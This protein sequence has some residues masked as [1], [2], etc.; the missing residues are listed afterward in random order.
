MKVSLS[1]LQDYVDISKLSPEELASEL[2]KRA[3]E[4]EELQKIGNPLEGPIV[5]GEIRSIT[6]H[7]DADKL[8]ITET[9]IGYNAD[10]SEHIEQI[11]CGARNI[12]VGQRIPVAYIGSKVVDRKNHSLLEIRKSKIRGVESN[13]MLCAAEELGLSNIENIKEQQGDGIYILYDPNNPEIPDLASKLQLGTPIAEVLGFKTDYVFDIGAR[14]NR[15]DALS[16]YGQAREISALL[17]SRGINAPLTPIPL[18]SIQEDPK[19]KNIKPQIEDFNDCSVFFT[20]AVEGLQVQESPAWLKERLEALGQNS[21]NNLVDVSNYVLLELGQPL[22]FYDRDRLQGDTLTA[23]KASPSEAFKSLKDLDYL[24]NPINLVI[25]DAAGPECLAGVMGGHRS[26]VSS[27]T[28]SIIIEAAAFNAASV[29][30]SARA[31]GIDS[32]SKRRFERGVDRATSRLAL[33]RA[34]S[35]LLDIAE[36]QGQKLSISSIQQCGDDQVPE[37]IV[38]LKTQDITR[39]LGLQLNPELIISTLE[40]LGLKYQ[41]TS[42]TDSLAFSIASFRQ[43]DLRRSIDLVEEIARLYGFDKIPNSAPRALLSK[44]NHNSKQTIQD[45]LVASGF[46]QAILSSLVAKS[47]NGL[48]EHAISMLNPL[49]S[50]HSMLRQSLLHGLIQAASRNY[51]YDRSLDIRLF[52]TGK[53]YFKAN[54][55]LASSLNAQINKETSSI[56]KSQVAAILVKTSKHWNEQQDASN[57]FYEFKSIIENLYPQAS[58]SSKAP[59]K[60]NRALEFSHPGTLAYVRLNQKNIGFI[61]KLHPRISKELG[62]ADDVYIFELDVVHNTNKPCFQDIASTPIIERDITVDINPELAPRLES[63]QILEL[64]NRESKAKNI[65]LLSRYQKNSL[66]P[67]SLSYRLKWQSLEGTLSGEEI[68]NNVSSIKNLL[69]REL[70]VTFRLV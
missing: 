61:A 40:P 58:F 64:M 3:F 14:S 2:S 1:W 29:R 56:E 13:G 41:T 45:I 52:E 31:A 60:F 68:D 50:E 47:L 65:K 35:L 10:A 43:N 46:S 44:N 11:V 27:S 32:E 19:I 23:R 39:Y 53:I 7:P 36:E 59:D 28:Q 22:H 20:V 30:R 33:L 25:A 49:S 4:V 16:I 21:I 57:D 26:Q 54:P 62:L 69:E 17:R 51:A 6:K 5:L 12:K 24:L 48:E 70:G 38:E 67:L 37:Q 18:R 55:E 34:L 63:S 42:K 66:S 15:G 9:C 8:Q